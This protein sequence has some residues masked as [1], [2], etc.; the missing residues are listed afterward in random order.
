MIRLGYLTRSREDLPPDDRWLTARELTGVDGRRTA[1]RISDWRLGRWTAKAAIGTLLEPATRAGSARASHPA[2]EV[3][4]AADGA[5]FAVAGGQTLPIALSLSHAAG[6]ALCAV[7]AAASAVGCDLERV[8]PRSAEFV[9]SYFT[10]GE[11]LAVERAAAPD[12]LANLIWSAKESALKAL[13]CGLRA[14]T[15]S[16]EVTLGPAAPGWGTFH[17]LATAERRTFRG[18]WCRI[19]DLVATLVSAPPAE[20]VDLDAPTRGASPL[21]FR[22]R[23][24]APVAVTPPSA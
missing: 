9:A 17:V 8:E 20:P 3:L 5:P 19:D 18:R 15:R 6:R 22:L 7:G 14:D 16:V 10:T 23:V 2:V 24:E 21:G 4:A 1:K 13:R 12:L 11:A